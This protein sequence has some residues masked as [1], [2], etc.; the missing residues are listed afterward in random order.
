[1]QSLRAIRGS[2]RRRWGT[3]EP[4]PFTVTSDGPGAGV[5]VAAGHVHNF[6]NRRWLEFRLVPLKVVYK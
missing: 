2:T 4:G 3:S 6:V 1:M 5:P